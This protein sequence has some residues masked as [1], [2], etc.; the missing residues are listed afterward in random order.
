MNPLRPMPHTRTRKYEWC[1][2]SLLSLLPLA[3]PLSVLARLRFCSD[4]V[5]SIRHFGSR[6]CVVGFKGGGFGGPP[7]PG[8]IDFVVPTTSL[9]LRHSPALREDALALEA[10]LQIS[11]LEDSIFLQTFER[12]WVDPLVR[13]WN[14]LQTD[15]YADMRL[16]FG[17][18]HG[19]TQL[20]LAGIVVE[21]DDEELWD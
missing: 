1:D 21:T 6:R 4:T 19:S 8:S 18:W 5:I 11:K 16:A 14:R 15:L 17:G 12:H 2:L 3:M 9:A 10:I 13:A 7:A 20:A